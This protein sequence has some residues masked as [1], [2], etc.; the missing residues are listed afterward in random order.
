[1]EVGPHLPNACAQLKNEVRDTCR[2]FLAQTN[3]LHFGILGLSM[4]SMAAN[5]PFRVKGR[6]G[7]LKK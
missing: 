3:P 6:G 1:M 7:V 2:P 5:K 4:I